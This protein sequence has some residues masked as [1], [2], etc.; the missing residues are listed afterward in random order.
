MHDQMLGL[1]DRWTSDDFTVA[2]LLFFNQFSGSEIE[3]VKHSIDA[4]W[5]KG[6]IR[7]AKEFYAMISKCG[8]CITNCIA[9]ENCKA[10][11]DALNAVDTRDQVMSYRTVVSY[12]SE[13]LRDF[14]L[15]IL[16]KNNI[17]GCDATI[18]TA[19]KVEPISTWRGKPLTFEAARSILVG[20][21]DDEAAPEV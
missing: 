9:D 2:L 18:P 6:P 11:L 12:E 7:N 17:F 3:W 10:C 1:F 4:T 8:D 21:L 13:L 14:S 15:C 19:P 16:Q 20:H 5:E